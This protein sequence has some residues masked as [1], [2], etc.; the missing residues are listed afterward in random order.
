MDVRRAKVR[1]LVVRRLARRS[2]VLSL[3]VVALLPVFG[4]GS[5][6]FSAH[7]DAALKPSAARWQLV[8]EP[9]LER[10]GACADGAIDSSEDHHPSCPQPT[11]PSL[12]IPGSPTTTNTSAWRS[13]SSELARSH[14][15]RGPPF[16]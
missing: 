9:A 1:G 10:I 16:A 6:H 15:A 5:Q 11:L 3:L 7:T 13:S 2:A 14:A 8:P 12:R 4:G